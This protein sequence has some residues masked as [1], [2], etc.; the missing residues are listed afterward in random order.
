M[1]ANTNQDEL[2]SNEGTV[3]LHM[4]FAL[5]QNQVSF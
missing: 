4:D 1:E 5:K 3:I 2:L